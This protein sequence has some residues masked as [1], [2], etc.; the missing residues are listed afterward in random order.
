M[1]DT[2]NLLPREEKK[3]RT[4]LSAVKTSTLIAI[5][6][7]V[8]VGSATSYYYISTFRLN[9][10]I[11]SLEASIERSRKEINNLASIE[12]V[13]RNLDARYR[14]LKTFL[15][16][17]PNYSYLFEEL[18]RRMPSSIVL[19]S[20]SIA[21]GSRLQVSGVT[22]TYV[23]IARFMYDLEDPNFSG[24]PSKFRSLFTQVSLNSVGSAQ[25]ESKDISFSVTVSFNPTL[26]KGE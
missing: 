17:R 5:I 1:P 3:Q 11:K 22:D 16:E 14:S 8:V 15:E 12:I 19:T 2:I 4:S 18:E 13:A 10:S 9:H 6:L 26:L 24:A 7:L 20:V 21:E 23:G 25:R